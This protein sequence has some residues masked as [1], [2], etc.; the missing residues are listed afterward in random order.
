MQYSKLSSYLIH[1]VQTRQSS[2]NYEGTVDW[3][4]LNSLVVNRTVRHYKKKYSFENLGT[5]HMETRLGYRSPLLITF[6]T[7]LSLSFE[8]I[9]K[10]VCPH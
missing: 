3:T 1:Y 2:S 4:E 10:V 7:A 8:E 9:A 5:T 6:S